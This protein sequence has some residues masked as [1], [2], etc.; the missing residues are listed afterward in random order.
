MT[1]L[2]V[3]LTILYWIIVVV[4]VFGLM[5]RKV[6]LGFTYGLIYYYSII[7]ILLGSNLFI[8]DGVFQLVTIISSFAKLTPQFLGRLC[9]VQGLSG[10]D[11]QFIHFFHA[12]SIFLLIVIIIMAAKYSF[13][14]ASFVSHSII[15]VICLL[16]LLSYTSF[17]SASLQ[18]LRPLYFHDV[19]GAYVYSSPSIKYFTGRHIAYG[20]IALLCEVF[21]VIGLP[22]L[23]LL[24]PFLQRKIN[25]IKIKPLLDQFQECY[26]DQYRWFAAYYLIC[27]QVIIAT[28]YV[29]SFNNSLYYVQTVSIIIVSIHV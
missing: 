23:L 11:Q 6:S 21:I 27:R 10:I 5:Q 4:L 12:V 8:S 22:L 1:V 2:V 7:D 24:Q 18:L 16:I 17:A 29:S 14:I 15:H 20:I 25:F 26:K 9:F 28:V 13:R 3:A 19:N